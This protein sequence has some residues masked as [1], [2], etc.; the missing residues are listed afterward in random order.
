[1]RNPYHRTVPI[2]H[3]LMDSLSR[4]TARTLSNS[5]GRAPTL[6]LAYFK[7]FRQTLSDRTESKNSWPRQFKSITHA[8]MM[9]PVFVVS[10]SKSTRPAPRWPPQTP[11]PVATPNSPTPGDETGG[12]YSADPRLAIR[13]AASFRRQLLP[14]NL[15][16]CPWCMRRS[17]SGPTM[18][19]SPS[20]FAQSSRP[21]FE[22]MMVEAFS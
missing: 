9:R 15:S 5:N 22:V 17:M 2:V 13:A 12:L 21:R 8:R 3:C 4:S 14:S 20:S 16:R 6:S 10:G 19:T 7:S 1:M 18:T 11:P